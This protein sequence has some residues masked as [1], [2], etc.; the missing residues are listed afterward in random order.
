MSIP[1]RNVKNVVTFHGL[2]LEPWRTV[3]FEQL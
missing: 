1:P 3:R 2:A